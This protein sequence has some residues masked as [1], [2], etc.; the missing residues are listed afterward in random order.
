VNLPLARD[1]S[2]FARELLNAHPELDQELRAA[3]EGG[4]TREAMLRFLA[5]GPPASVEAPSVEGV[6]RR[7]RQLRARVMLRTMQRDLAGLAAVGEVCSTITTLAEIAVSAGL[8]AIEAELAPPQLGVTLPQAGVT[9]PQAGVAAAA[10][11]RPPGRLIVVGMGKLGGSELNVSSDIDLV[12][13]YTEEG[14]ATFTTADGRE[15]SYHEHFNALGR[16]L[17]A[18]LGQ[19]TA[20]GMLFRVDMRLRPWGDAGPLAMSID[21]LEQYLLVHGREWERYAWIKGRPLSGDAEALAQ[22][23]AV[24]RPFVFRKYLDYGA[25]AAMRELHAQSAPRWAGA[26][27]PTTSNWARAAFAKSSSSRRPIN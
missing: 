2:R 19:V 24:V 25:I 21:A 10:G 12:F 27:M 6:G 20:D 1:Y 5:S 26:N 11:G 13:L 3:G 8:A 4:W 23:G 14:D 9:L 7:L 22:L 18:L 15:R 17:V 16:R